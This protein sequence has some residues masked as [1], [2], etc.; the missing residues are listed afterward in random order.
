M[1]CSGV[2]LAIVHQ[3]PVGVVQGYGEVERVSFENISGCAVPVNKDIISIVGVFYQRLL[4]FIEKVRPGFTAFITHSPQQCV[5]CII[6]WQGFPFTAF[7]YLPVHISAFGIVYQAGHSVTVAAVGVVFRNRACT[8]Y[9]NSGPALYLIFL[10][11]ETKIGK[12]HNNQ[13]QRQYS[14]FHGVLLSCQKPKM[15]L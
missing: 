5:D 11:A 8:G 10:T 3:L 4:I 6:C 14:F 12:T 1:I 13:Y 15:R 7:D 9:V 2:Q